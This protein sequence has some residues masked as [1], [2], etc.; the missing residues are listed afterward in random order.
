VN[1]RR[2]KNQVAGKNGPTEVPL[3]GGRRLD[4]LTPNGR[5][6]AIERTTAGLEDAA[7]RLRDTDASQRVPQVPSRIWAPLPP[8]FSEF[9]QQ[10]LM[11][12]TFVDADAKRVNPM[13]CKF[14]LQH[15]DRSVPVKPEDCCQQPAVEQES[16]SGRP[17][18]R[19][20]LNQRRGRRDLLAATNGDGLTFSF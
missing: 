6:T 3:P 11:T 15:S 20:H 4:A 18:C 12:I 2:A 8:P 1:H 17:Y 13:Q 9:E 14:V 19:D 16:A 10:K 5:A 7:R